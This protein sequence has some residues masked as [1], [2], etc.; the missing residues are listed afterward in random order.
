MEGNC[1]EFQQFAYAYVLSIDEKYWNRL[2]QRV[3]AG[4]VEHV[5][6]RKNAVTPFQVDQLLF[7]VTAPDKRQVLGVA[8]FLDCITGNSLE[9]WKKYGSESGFP[10]FGEYRAF[11]EFKEQATVIRFNHFREILHPK[12]K[13]E[14]VQVLGMQHRFSIG[15]YLDR[16]SALSLI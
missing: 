4:L 14:T 5:F 3:Q 9:L 13:E 12:S 1:L 15:Q 7:Y 11:I 16:E 2:I 6:V 10:T 8:D